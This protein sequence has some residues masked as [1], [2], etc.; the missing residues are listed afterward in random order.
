MNLK[1]AILFGIVLWVLVFF[2]ISILMFG[3]KL[4]ETTLFLI[5]YILLIPLVIL[6]SRFY[7]KKSKRNVSEGFSLGIIFVLTGLVLDAIITVPL[8]VKDYSFF[9]DINL[10][11]GLIEII[12]ITTLFGKVGNKIHK[13][14]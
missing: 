2:E 5:H 7:F 8:F 9:L 12:V 1:R 11:I 4:T 13:S 14:K 3:F 6:T 10:L